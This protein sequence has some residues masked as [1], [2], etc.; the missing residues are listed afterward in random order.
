MSVDLDASLLVAL[1]TSDAFTQRAHDFLDAE[2]P[3]LV[4]SDFAAAE[5]ASA[6]ARMTRTH[7]STLDDARIVLT[8]FDVWRSRVAD[9]PHIV[10]AD[11]AVAALFT[12][13]LDLTLRTADAINIA[14]AQRVGATLATFDTKMAASARAVGTPI[15]DA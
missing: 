11:V 15:A 13:R 4:V 3:I 1:L 9:G 6:V 5:F 14:I 7:E 8:D 12:R 2:L 10:P